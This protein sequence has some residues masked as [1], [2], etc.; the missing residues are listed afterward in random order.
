MNHKPDLLLTFEYTPEIVYPD[1]RIDV[2]ETVRNIIPQAGVDHVVGLIKG[3]VAPI[4]NWYVG[5]FQGNYTPTS[6]TTSGDLQTSAQESQAYEE[7][8]RPLW[9]NAYDGVGVIDNIANRAVF[10]FNAARTIYGAFIVSNSVKGGNTG[11]LLSIARFASPRSV[12][13]GA[14][15]RVAAGLTLVPTNLI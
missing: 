7:A 8:T 14:Q 6:G 4:A 1:G 11:L 10:T 3:D 9:Q 2:G 13:V 12:D 15:L 5:V